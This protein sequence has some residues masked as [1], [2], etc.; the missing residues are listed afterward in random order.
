MATR[1]NFINETKRIMDKLRSNSNYNG[2][3]MGNKLISG[4]F[5]LPN[6][7]EVVLK[8]M[9]NEIDGLLIKE[10]SE[11]SPTGFYGLSPVENTKIMVSLIV[12][13][14]RGTDEIKGNSDKYSEIINTLFNATYP[15][16]N[17]VHFNV[18]SLE[19]P[20][21]KTN[22]DSFLELFSCQDK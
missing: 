8:K 7:F 12:R 18:D 19:I 4:N 16:F 6:T 11:I 17:Y 2:I 15:D 21:K 20:P 22:R 13:F 1:N 9:N 3:I 10:V 14:K 5:Q